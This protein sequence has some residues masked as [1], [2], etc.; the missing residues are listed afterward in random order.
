MQI[1]SALSF[2]NIVLSFASGAGHRNQIMHE[3]L[4]LEEQGFFL[5]DDLK[6]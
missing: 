1:M 2:S 6:I 3:I 5:H 4:E